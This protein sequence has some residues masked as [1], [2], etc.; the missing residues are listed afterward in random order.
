MTTTEPR[1]PLVEEDKL[2]PLTTKPTGRLYRIISVGA[3]DEEANAYRLMYE[4]ANR[5]I[6]GSGYDTDFNV[7]CKIPT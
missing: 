3:W 5:K 4:S 6:Q 1:S 7:K 2:Y